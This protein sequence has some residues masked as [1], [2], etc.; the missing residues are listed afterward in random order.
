MTFPK[1]RVA[2]SLF[3]FLSWLGFLFYLVLER[4]TIVVSQPQL[5]ISQLIVVAELR[6]VEGVPDAQVA[7]KEVLW[8]AH[9]ADQKQ[10][11]IVLPD[12]ALAQ[13]YKGAGVYVV[14]LRKREGGFSIAPAP[15]PNVPTPR[16]YPWNA[17]TRAQVEIVLTSK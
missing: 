16:I 12:L 11:K 8:S 6:D 13:G 10:D 9:A 1:V 7:V 2:V 4:R 5:L 3:L 15:T 14:P 17:E